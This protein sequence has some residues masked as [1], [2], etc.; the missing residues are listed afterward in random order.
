MKI[1]F[2]KENPACEFTHVLDNGKE[3][4]IGFTAIDQLDILSWSRSKDGFKWPDECWKTEIVDG[5]KVRKIDAESLDADTRKRMVLD[6][7]KLGASKLKTISGI[8][9]DLEEE[10]KP[11]EDVIESF[12]LDEKADILY[13][14]SET[15]L[16]FNI[17]FK[18]W[19]EGSKK[20][21][22]KMAIN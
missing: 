7:F 19:L 11:I 22:N 20:K 12:S 1:K 10:S 8:E 16:E 13:L 2:N 9:M 18:M 5:K 17:W 14:I 3:I 6:D 21:S 4:K 15:Y